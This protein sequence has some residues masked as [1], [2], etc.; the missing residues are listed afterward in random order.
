[1]AAGDTDR[2]ESFND[3][4]CVAVSVSPNVAIRH[5]L[6]SPPSFRL[7][8]GSVQPRVGVDQGAE[9][10]APFA[11]LRHAPNAARQRVSGEVVFTAEGSGVSAPTMLRRD[12]SDG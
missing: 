9:A 8:D 12:M 11:S 6:V 4:D 10:S 5:Q 1:M 7:L 2:D 3:P